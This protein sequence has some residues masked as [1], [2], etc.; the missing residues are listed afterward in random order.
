MRVKR[1]PADPVARLRTITEPMLQQRLA[2]LAQWKLEGGRYLPVAPGPEL[3]RRTGVR[4]SGNDLQ[5][6]LTAKEIAGVHF[7]LKRLLKRIDSGEIS[8][9]ATP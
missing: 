7:Q 6:G 4:R 9:A 8:V 3:P 2:V 5:M 1:L